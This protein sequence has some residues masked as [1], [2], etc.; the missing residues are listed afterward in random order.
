[1]NTGLR[2]PQCDRLVDADLG[3]VGDRQVAE[4]GGDGG[5]ERAA[6]HPEHVTPVVAQQ[7]EHRQ[8]GEVV[9]GL[10]LREGRGLVQAAPDEVGHQDDQ[11]AQP[12]RDA[13]ADAVLDVVGEGHHRDEHHG[14]ED[15]A[16]LGAGQRPGGEEG[17]AV[18]GGVLERQ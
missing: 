18:V 12:E 15:L 16:A 4:H 7:V 5:D 17:P 2:Q 11:R 13:P 3:A 9:V 1:M 6:D 8:P 14:G 10:G